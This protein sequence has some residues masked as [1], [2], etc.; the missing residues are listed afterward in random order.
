MIRVFVHVL[1]ATVMGRELPWRRAL[2]P[3]VEFTLDSNISLLLLLHTSIIGGLW[4]AELVVRNLFTSVNLPAGAVASVQI[5]W[6][7]IRPELFLEKK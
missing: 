2:R 5:G 6:Q 3:G 4:E 1:V 7:K